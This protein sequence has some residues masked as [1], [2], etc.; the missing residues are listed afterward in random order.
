MLNSRGRVRIDVFGGHAFGHTCVVTLKPM[1]NSFS[2]LRGSRSL[3]WSIP[4]SHVARITDSR[5]LFGHDP[6][7]MALQVL[8]GSWGPASPPTKEVLRSL[9][10]AYRQRQVYPLVIA[11]TDQTHNVWL[12][13]PSEDSTVTGPLPLSQATRILQACLK[14]PSGAAARNLLIRYFDSLTTTA[15]PG[16]S[17]TGLFAS[18]FLRSSAPERGD[19]GVMGE[20]AE[21]LLALRGESLIKALGFHTSWEGSSVVLLKN[22]ADATRAVAVLLEDKESFSAK[23]ERFL[24][25]P[26]SHGLSVA[27]AKEVPWLIALRGSQIRLYSAKPNAGVGRKGQSETFFEVDLAV[28][29]DHYK[30]LV[31]LVFS[32]DALGPKGSTEEFLRDSSRFAA[33]LGKRLRTRVYEEVIP[34]LS[35]AVAKEM[36]RL[37]MALDQ[38]GLDV[39]YGATLRILF[40][41]LFQAYGEDRALL[42]YGRNTTYDRHALKSIAKE[43]AEQ[44]S[45]AQQA[46]A[47]SGSSSDS[48]YRDLLTVWAVIDKGDHSW[49]VPAYNGGLFSDDDLEGALLAQITLSNDIFVGALRSLLVDVTDDNVS[50]PVDFR[51]L[52]VREFG[53]IYEGLLESSLSLAESD[54]VI[55]KDGTWIPAKDGVAPLAQA[56]DPYFHNASGA[57]KSTGSYFTPSFLVDHLLEHSLVPALDQHLGEIAQLLDD[58]DQP[59]AARK[60][61]DFRVA[62]LAMGSGHF[63]V[64]AID[65]ME[66]KMVAFLNDHPLPEIEDE[67]K[68]LER[69]AHEALGELSQDIEIARSSL[70]RRQIARRCIYGLDINKIAVELARV[71]IWIHTFVPGLA[72]SSLDHGLVWGNSLTGIGDI[73]E[74]IKELDPPIKGQ[75]A[76]TVGVFRG[77]IEDQLKG[78]SDLLSQVAAA[79]EATAYDVQ[80]AQRI[81]LQAQ[82]QA[83]PT[84]T[85]FDLAIAVRLG[86]VKASTVGRQEVAAEVAKSDAVVNLVSMLRPAHMPYLFPEVF[87]RE[88]AGFDVLIGNPPWEKIKVEIQRWWSIRE[89]G[90]MGLSQSRR[91]QRIAE[92][93]QSRPDVQ[94]EY[95]EEL[96][97]AEFLRRV[98]SRG[99]FPGFSTGD[100]DLYKAFALRYMQTIGRGGYIGVVLPV[101]SFLLLGSKEWREEVL[102]KASFKK[103]TFLVNHQEWLFEKVH[104]QYIIGLVA[105]HNEP[106]PTISFNGPF[107]SLEAFSEG[108]EKVTEVSVEWFKEWTSDYS[109]PM[110]PDAKSFEVFLALR[111]H[112]RFDAT[113]QFEFRPYSE[114]HMSNSQHLWKDVDGP[115]AE[116]IPVLSSAAF[117]IW[118]PDAGYPFGYVPRK[119]I[120][121][122]LRRKLARQVRLP[123]SAFYGM[124]P[125]QIEILPI[126]KARI[127]FASRTNSGNQRTMSCCLVPPSVA[128]VHAAP[129]L[130]RRSGAT[131]DEAYVLGVLS[132]IPFD[133]YARKFVDQNF[134]FF[135]LAPMP[136]PRP[137]PNNPLRQRVIT[138]AGRL[139]AVDD[140]FA[141]WAKEVGVEVGTVTT[142][143]EKE[144]LI[145]ELDAVVAH[146][147]GLTEA[148]LIHIFATFHIGWN[149]HERL[150]KVRA[151]YQRLEGKDL[152][153]KP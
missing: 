79:S 80:E 138:I 151:H 76:G 67:L 62:D 102:T 137:A 42:P 55:D 131:C 69:A 92:L 142:Q 33:S 114:L 135:T 103:V 43:L 120:E 48:Y 128:L 75:R 109:F 139:A 6:Y 22:N 39:A 35:V 96:A 50:G 140:R 152:V 58:G 141:T 9:F 53:T 36:T 56:G 68:S 19:W 21:S 91:K 14:E 44:S 143:G 41:I 70:L 111:K 51:S 8:V 106:S 25:S 99:P 87:L 119:V 77:I 125:L 129:Y 34:T 3:T 144:E 4:P 16:V 5:A 90:L 45:A 86:I 126:D 93:Q 105:I 65:Q 127:A 72:M 81:A 27:Q 20:R 71:A 98:L 63:L 118:N 61:F 32:A 123:A 47:Q 83:A 78:A 110:M 108:R 117:D 64:S 85:L 153:T 82:S 59:Q 60:F 107:R 30:P 145:A 122:E 97:Q 116:V 136:I 31:P 29:D 26:V 49:G 95:I 18:H 73:D 38:A 130:V 112:P 10:T 74:A 94:Q 134:G 89:P 13:G 17:N 101:G 40:R 23:S 24:Q 133:W 11:L 124:S 54:L 37:G 15:M 113:E 146:L 12:Y 104:Q 132:S 46:V 66:T 52:S 7:G 1:T 57:R 115:S 148:Q 121:K 100:S 149:Y 147:Y 84:K 150:E 28:V 88:R 2:A